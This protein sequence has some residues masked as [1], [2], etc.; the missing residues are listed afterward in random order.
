[1]SSLQR[2]FHFGKRRY[3]TCFLTFLLVFYFIKNCSYNSLHPRRFSSYSNFH[4]S[5]AIMNFIQIKQS[6][7]HRELQEQEVFAHV[8]VKNV[9]NLSHKVVSSFVEK[10]SLHLWKAIWDERYRNNNAIVI[11]GMVNRRSRVCFRKKMKTRI[12]KLH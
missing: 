11:L 8:G 10:R 1:M 7:L 6:S 12:E 4:H 5:L 3:A 9:T 2:V